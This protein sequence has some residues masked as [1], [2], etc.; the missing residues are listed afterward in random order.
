MSNVIFQLR[1][2]HVAAMGQVAE[3]NFFDR[4]A[5][6]LRKT[7]PDTTAGM[8]DEE[9]RERVRNGRNRAAP[10]GLR[11]EKQVMWFVDSAMILGETFDTGEVHPWARAILID[12]ARSADDRGRT[13][14]ETAVEKWHDSRG[15]D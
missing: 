10:Y 7:F 6:H 4:G 5:I 9:L 13:V 12:P 2:E 3:E 14:L 1:D 15:L 11:S 8:S